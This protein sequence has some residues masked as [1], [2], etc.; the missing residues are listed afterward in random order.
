MRLRH[1]SSRSSYIGEAKT[2]MCIIRTSYTHS[3]LPFICFWFYGLSP[4]CFCCCCCCCHNSC[5]NNLAVQPPP[6]PPP[7][8]PPRRRRR[9]EAGG[10]AAA[11]LLCC[12]CCCC[13]CAAAAVPSQ[14]CCCCA[15]VL[16]YQVSYLGRL[17]EYL[18][19]YVQRRN[20]TWI[21]H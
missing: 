2:C 16:T 10:A 18:V 12:C 9:A 3:S 4:I 21:F 20:F 14:L 8:P 1:R 7:P 19:I 11:T 6:P 5:E 17:Y 15:A 13:C